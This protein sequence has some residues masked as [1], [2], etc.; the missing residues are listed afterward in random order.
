MQFVKY[1]AELRGYLKALQHLNGP[2]YNFGVK[3]FDFDGNVDSFIQNYDHG[4]PVIGS[5]L[6]EFNEIKTKIYDLVMNGM[7]SLEKFPSKRHFEYYENYLM[8]TINEYYGLAST[9]ENKKGVFHPLI[10][11]PVYSL[12]MEGESEICNFFFL[13]KIK[14]YYVLTYLRKKEK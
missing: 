13:V 3:H 9:T 5:S 4:L 2:K 8:E 7:I 10:K 11:G 6:I 1:I 14:K 12:K